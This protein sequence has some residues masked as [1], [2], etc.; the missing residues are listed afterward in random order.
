MSHV[1]HPGSPHPPAPRHLLEAG[2]RHLQQGQFEQ[3]RHLAD[4][5]IA[6]HPDDPFSLVFA[7]EVQLAVNEPQ[8]ALNLIE[9]A[10][11]HANGDVALQVKKAQ[12]LLQMGRRADAMATASSAAIHADANGQAL[13]RIGSIF[14]NG[15]DP[16]GAIPY[17]KRA[18]ALIGDAP[19]LLYDLAAAQFFTGQFDQAEQNL[20][21]LLTIVPQAGHALYLRST[22]RRQTHDN[23]HV[24]DLQARLKTGFSD[25]SAHAACLYALSKEQEDLG[26]DDLSFA[27][28][29][30]AAARMRSTLRYDVGSERDALASIRDA[31]TV[32]QMDLPTA[33]HDDDGAIF[34][35][36]M[37]RTGTTLVERILGGQGRIAPAGELLDFGNA[38]GAAVQRV[39][40]TQPTLTAAQA[41]LSIDFASLGRDYIGA[42]RQAAGGHHRFIDKMPV[43]YLYCGMIAKALPNA[44]IIHVRR[45]PLDSCYAVFKTLFYGAYHFSYDLQELATYYIAYHQTMQHWHEVMPGKILDVHYEDLVSNTEREAQRILAWCGLAT[46][47]PNLDEASVA[48]RPF[49]TAS[50][51]QV[52]EPIHRRS[53]LKSRRHAKGLA[54]LSDA[55]AAAGI[56][57]R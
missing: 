55:L 7:S 20:D 23:N 57:V 44:R 40:A 38:L 50:A 42:A 17:F 56:D 12:L 37:P 35:V 30:Q 10:I 22:L 14:N 25:A 24:A 34:I 39:L 27:T 52:R 33:G 36:G 8:A 3:A 6:A 1:V 31:F 13:W 18:R 9:Q 28:L 47:R 43:N 49:A 4:R 2:Y 45:D 16:A 41:S 48:A 54:P 5:L 26:D 53:V 51:A 19:G 46:D 21:R 11:S 32:Q 29:V 15:N